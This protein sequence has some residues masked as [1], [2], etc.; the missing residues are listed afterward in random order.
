MGFTHIEL[1]P[2]TEHPLDASWGY[3]STGFF[4]PTSRYGAPDDFR[5][6][7]DYCHVNNIGVILDW[8]GG[9]FPKDAHGFSQ[10]DGTAL[11]EH[12][13]PRRGEHREWG[14]M[15]FNYAR[16]EVRSFLISNALYWIKE[17]H[18]DGLRVDA[19]AAMLYLD[20]GRAEHDWLP[21]V[22]GGNE[23]LEAIDFLREL[24]DKLLSHHPGTVMIA[25]E[26]TA[27]PEVTR[28]SWVG[29]LGF[30]MKWNMGWMHD[31]LAYMQKDPVHRHY[32]HDK[33]S[34]GMLYSFHEN[35]VL[36][37]SQDEV[38]H[39]KGSMIGRMPGDN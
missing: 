36:P 28:P 22:H 9:H 24:N 27:W 18:L 33:L 8:V 19:V 21:N 17:F 16:H 25:E 1:M 4:A 13:D 38:V 31:T 32:H 20:Y 23:N 6:F 26:S 29:G 15:V 14:T 37:F 11:Y 39:G 7:V 5:F 12:E 35:F 30:S 3:Q 2:I 10:F 34:F